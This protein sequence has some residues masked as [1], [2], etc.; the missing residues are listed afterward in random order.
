MTSIEITAQ[1]DHLQKI[2]RSKPYISISELIWNSLDADSKKVD[3]SYVPND[4]GGIDKIIISDDGEGFPRDIA[5][6]YFGSLG[7]SWKSSVVSSKSGRQL[8]GKQGQGRFKAFSLGYNV[9]WKVKYQKNEGKIYEYEIHGVESHLNKFDITDELESESH[10]T[11]V[12]VEISNL[13]KQFKLL[14]SEV[15]LQTFPSV[16]APYLSNYKGISISFDGLKMDISE[17][18]QDIKEYN[19]SKKISDGE[20]EYSFSVKMIE[21]NSSTIKELFFC[22]SSGFPLKKY[23]KQ[24]RYIGDYGFTAYLRSSFFEELYNNGEI[25]LVEMNDDLLPVIKECIGGIKEYFVDRYLEDQKTIIETWKEEEVYPY[26]E[27]VIEDSVEGVEKKVFDI[28]ALNL[29]HHVED[30][31][32]VNRTQK[33]LQFRLLKQ[34]IESNPSDL[35]GIL[36]EVISLPENVINELKELLEYSSFSSIISASKTI[37]DRIRYLK[38]IEEIVFD[39]DL[40][41]RLKER[42]QLHK[43]LSDNA[44]IFGDQFHL[45]VNDQSLSEVLK[46]HKKILGEDIIIDEPV[47]RLDGTKGI[48]DL[49]LSRSVPKN[50]SDEFE[51]LVVE[52]KAPRVKITQK[53]VNQITSY[54]TAIAK[55]ERFKSLKVRWEFWVLSNEVDDVVELMMNQKKSS[56]NI[57]YEFTEGV[58]ITVKVKTW[59]MVLAESNHRYQFV[60]DQLQLNID[61]EDGLEYLRK[62]YSE[63]VGDLITETSSDSN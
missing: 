1:K 50:H 7:G 42:S 20:N 59:S 2:S 22:D 5:E 62:T 16:F 40:K 38:G 33:A 32:S 14:D 37:T 15:S 54:A 52:L 4:L 17:Q 11:G 56:D 35:S 46:K 57:I 53:E 18:I 45:T 28:L 51:Y 25:D 34:A 58:N 9:I 23:D 44:W 49:M 3:V 47:T 8:H 30:F 61:K 48:V 39:V 21:W 36:T 31:N 29:N 43:I 6:S 24:I 63:Y 13:V 19:L 60:K 26:S 10:T 12:T 55:D 27:Q 41:K